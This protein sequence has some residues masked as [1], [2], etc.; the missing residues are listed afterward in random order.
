MSRA[1][2]IQ[3]NFTTGEVDPL[4]KSRIDINQYYNALDQ[5]R[6]VLIQPQG[7]IERRPGLQFI[8]EL[9]SAAN[10]QNGIKLIPFEF[11]TT[12]SYMLLF[13]HNRMYI[14]KNK[15]LVTNINSSGNDY[16]TTTIGSTVL[17]TMDHTQSADT[18][19]LVQEDMAPKKIVRGG[20][21]STWTISDL[22]FEFIP[23]FNFT[24]SETTINQ[25]ITPSAVDGNITITAGGNVFSSGNVNQYIEAND[26]I[27]RARITRFVSATSVEAIV[28]I[29]FFNTSAIASG[30]T[31]IDG[32][33][34]DSWSS[35]KGYPRTCTFHEGR[36]YF[37]GVKSR[38]NTI[39]ASRVARFFD[40]NPGEALDDDSLEL[41]IST[42]STNAITGMFSGR[43]LQIFTKGGEFFLPQSTLDP[44]TPTNVVVNGATRRGSQ[45]GIKPVGAESG[46]LFIQRAGKSLREFLFS[47]VEL[48]YISNNISL[49]SSHLLKSPS[50]MALRKA[51]S[52]TDGDLLLLVNS[53]DGS[54]AT[55]S[56][57]RGQNVIAPTLST[58]D[59][60]FL[61]VGV[62]VDQIYFVI[63]RT[64]SSATKYYV[65]CFNDDNTTDSTKLLSGSSKP[66]STTVTGL[67][68]LEGKTV[69]VIADD[70][71]QTNKTVSSGQITLDAVPTTYVEI[72]LDYTPIIKTLP[73]ELKLSSGNIVAQKKRIVEATVNLYLSQN[74]TLNDNAFSFVAG[75]FFTGK[76]RR[77]PMLGYDRDGQMTFSQT[78]PLFFNLLGIE[79]KV[80]VG[81]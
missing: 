11:S 46:T 44:I 78:D 80:S 24:A 62:D 70:Q 25:T 39:F 73:V 61:N 7:G 38:P 23:K 55:Y 48:S 81:Q 17:A 74:L 28:E 77:K 12:Q 56:I 16:L 60:E 53:T 20:S 9:P 50:D 58:T 15:E 4:L 13:V 36:L 67:S 63:K 22:S 18:L 76:K 52:T 47:D 19:I 37:G 64:I 75:D 65:E 8:F 5:A 27:G 69:R 51:T 40:F 54:L 41:T 33:Y 14:F 30:G 43:D 2:T 29:P 3:T 6:N 68:H 42:D 32:G 45:E 21:H 66:S 1:V 34:E 10:P 57:L 49:L 31:F 26:G 59:G 35:T 71:M 72:G 79:Y